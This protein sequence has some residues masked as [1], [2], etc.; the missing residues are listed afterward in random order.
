MYTLRV[1][2]NTP[3]LRLSSQRHTCNIEPEKS[4]LTYNVPANERGV[5]KTEI[6]T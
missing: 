3:R 4:W 2:V 1:H 5:M 6:R